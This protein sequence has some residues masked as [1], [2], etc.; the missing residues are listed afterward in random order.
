MSGESGAGKTVATKHV[1]SYLAE[2]AGSVDGEIAQKI[3]VANPVLEAFGNAK[4]I[5]NDN[6]SRFGKWIEV[7]FDKRLR[8]CGAR[9][10]NYLLEKAR[11]TDQHDGE[12]NFHIFY[13]LTNGGPSRL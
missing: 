1:L 5:V 10:I 2:V 11:V 3:L 8:I 4:T 6:S 12:R 7:L 13:Q 9:I